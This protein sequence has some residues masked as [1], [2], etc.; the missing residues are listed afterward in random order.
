M[1]VAKASKYIEALPHSASNLAIP[2]MVLPSLVKCCCA[3]ACLWQANRKPIAIHRLYIVTCWCAKYPSVLLNSCLSI[4]QSLAIPSPAF[5]NHKMSLCC[6]MGL[7]KSHL[8]RLRTHSHLAKGC[9]NMQ[10]LGYGQPKQ[11]LSFTCPHEFVELPAA[12]ALAASSL[13]RCLRKSSY[14]CCAKEG[15]ASRRSVSCL[16][17]DASL[18]GKSTPHL[19]PQEP[20]TA[21]CMVMNPGGVTKTSPSHKG[22]M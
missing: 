20:T 16:A 18:R 11:L 2:C 7:G 12:G 17:T 14:P 1:S 10:E 13:I 6:M 21:S 9:G 19:K 4:L 15:W 22:T 8:Y 5:L 3:V